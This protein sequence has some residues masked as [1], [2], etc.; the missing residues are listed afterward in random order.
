MRRFSSLLL[1]LTMACVW[2]ATAGAAVPGR[3]DGAPEPRE[4]RAAVA[5]ATSGEAADRQ[6]LRAFLLRGG[7][8]QGVAERARLRE[9][10]RFAEADAVRDALADR[11]I[12]LEDGPT[13]T[14]W[15]VVR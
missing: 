1:G 5:A 7:G 2:S 3:A 11:G 6:T 13:G 14:S 10:K 12:L 8:P 4:L 9:E 15:R